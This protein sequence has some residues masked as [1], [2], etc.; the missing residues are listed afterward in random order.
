MSETWEFSGE[1]PVAKS[2]VLTLTIASHEHLNRI[3]EQAFLVPGQRLC[4]SRKR[5]GFIAPGGPGGSVNR[6]GIGAIVS[7]TPRRGRTVVVPVH[8]GSS[9]G[10][11]HALEALFGMGTRRRGTVDVAWPGGVKN[12]LYGVRAG[13]R[14]RFPEIPCSYDAPGTSLRQYRRCVSRALGDLVR[15]GVIT[16]RE[17]RRFFTSAMIA[18]RRP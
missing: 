3:G 12:R 11:Q 1:A 10:S 6:D 16:S 5:P 4:L 8:A 9:F 7:F 15:S 14:I 17:K 2:V 18:F 13:E